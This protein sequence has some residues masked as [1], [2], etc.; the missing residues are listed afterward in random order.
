MCYHQKIPTVTNV[1]YD[2]A[3]TVRPISHCLPAIL[4]FDGL[5]KIRMVPLLY[6]NIAWMMKGFYEFSQFDIGLRNL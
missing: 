5:D 2:P 1:K 4:E 6:N 3:C